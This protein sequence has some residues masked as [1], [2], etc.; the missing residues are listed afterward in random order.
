MYRMS[1]SGY[2]AFHIHSIAGKINS[3]MD[4]EKQLDSVKLPE[5]ISLDCFISP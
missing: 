5:R 1:E 2:D 3:L 4:E